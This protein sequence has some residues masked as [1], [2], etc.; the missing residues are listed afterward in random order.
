MSVS[1]PQELASLVMAAKMFSSRPCTGVG[2]GLPAAAW[3]S[4]S[5]EGFAA[6]AKLVCSLQNSVGS[7]ALVLL[8]CGHACMSCN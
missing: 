2:C 5:S 4:D 3:G 6:F 1:Q 7:S 8:A